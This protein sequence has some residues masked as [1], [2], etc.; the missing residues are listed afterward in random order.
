MDAED[1]FDFYGLNQPDD[2]QSPLAKTLTTFEDS[3]PFAETPDTTSE[4]ARL[5][6]PE[7]ADRL[8]RVF[9]SHGILDDDPLPDSPPQPLHKQ[10][11][12]VGRRR[13][14]EA[15]EHMTPEFRRLLEANNF[16]YE[17]LGEIAREMADAGVSS[18]MEDALGNL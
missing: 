3:D 11:P 12:A 18:E 13:S 1:F 9:M 7:A 14:R 6:S 10:A 5:H 8:N 2:E 17:R 4:F 15:Y 16:G